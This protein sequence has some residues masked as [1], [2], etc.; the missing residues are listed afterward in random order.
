MNSELCL[1]T[2][3]SLNHGYMRMKRMNSEATDQKS[4]VGFSGERTR[5]SDL[6]SAPSPNRCS[7]RRLFCFRP[8]VAGL[9]SAYASPRRFFRILDASSLL[10]QKSLRT[11]MR[12]VLNEYTDFTNPDRALLSNVPVAAGVSP[13][14]PNRCSRHDCLYSREN[15]QGPSAST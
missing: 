14:K 5:R 6:R 12:S 3:K 10:A 13:A 1:L 7:R 2:S 4:E 15:D 8:A 9:W 11:L